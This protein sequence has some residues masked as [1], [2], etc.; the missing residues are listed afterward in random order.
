MLTEAAFT[1]RYPEFATATAGLVQAVLDE[2]ELNLA[3]DWGDRED[4]A[5]GLATAHHLAL[6]PFGRS[7]DLVDKSGETQ[8]GRRLE[9][10]KR[11]F[12]CGRRR[13]V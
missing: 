8:Y 4:E 3:D 11:M 2:Q 12:A 13:V 6:S 1:T 10:L 9:L 7:A 5:H